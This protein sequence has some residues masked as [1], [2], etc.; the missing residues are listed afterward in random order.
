MGVNPRAERLPDTTTAS[1]VAHLLANFTSH[2]VSS[3]ICEGVFEKFPRL[4]SLTEGGVAW[5]PPD[6]AAGREYKALR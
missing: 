3:L 5:L 2:P 6:V 1:Y 4:K